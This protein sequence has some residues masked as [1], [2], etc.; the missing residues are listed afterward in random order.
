MRP[1]P[2]RDRVFQRRRDGLLTDQLIK[3]SATVSSSKNCICHIEILLKKN[4]KL[5]QAYLWHPPKP[6]WAAS[7]KI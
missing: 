2:S 7:V 3:I 1:S 4:K 6:R 5:A